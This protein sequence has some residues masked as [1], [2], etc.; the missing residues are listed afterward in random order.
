MHFA[1]LLIIIVFLAPVKINTMRFIKFMLF[2]VVLPCF[3]HA[4]QVPVKEGNV[5]MGKQ[6]LW[7]FT[8]TYDHPKNAVIDAMENNMDNAKLKR[9]SKK[10]GVFTYKAASWPTI[11]NNKADY[12]YKV[13]SSKGHVMLSLAVSKGYD[14]YVT[15]TNDAEMAGKINTYLQNLDIQIANAEKLKVKEE[16]LKQMKSSNETLAKQA[17]DAKKA[18]EKKVQEIN[19][20]RKQ[21]EAPLPVK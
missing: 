19:A 18:E 16:E 13:K 6:K 9:T 20:L 15:S 12:Y 10:K 7:S 4:Q 17:A 1:A 21:Q 11:S 8:A 3:A 5:K 14:N 2:A